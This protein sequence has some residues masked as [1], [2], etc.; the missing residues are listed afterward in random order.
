MRSRF[1]R[2]FAALL[3]G[4][5]IAQAIPILI[6]PILTRLYSPS[7]FGMLALYLG[8]VNILAVVATGRYEAAIV[9]PKSSK[10]AAGILALCFILTLATVLLVALVL[11]GFGDTLLEL[12]DAT[13][14]GALVYLLPISILL[15]ASMQILNYW[16]TR[17]GSFANIATAQVGQSLGSAFLQPSLKLLGYNGGLI[18][19]NL[20]ARAVG[21]AILARSVLK[22][23][24]ELFFK[25]EWR[26]LLL[27]A[28]THS[29]FPRANLPHAL[30]D[31]A[32]NSGSVMLLASLFGQSVLGLYSL[33]LRVLQVPVGIIGSALSQLL[34]KE[35]SRRKNE[36]RPLYP[37]VKRVF[38]YLLTIALPSF[39]LLYLF[40]P[41]LFGLVFGKEWREAGEYGRLLIPYLLLNFLLSPLSQLPILLEWQKEI[42]HISLIGNVG[43]LAIIWIAHPYGIETTL[44]LLSLF[45]VLYYLNTLYLLRKELLCYEQRVINS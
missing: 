8:L 26:H 10:D 4:T 16:M 45:M 18:L 39:L 28:K 12:L 29:T 33:A 20:G 24:K 31:I 38:L 32:K 23:D 2:D 36:Q 5:T 34:Y 17:K 42:F 13:E 9:L 15:A 7:E 1:F 14:L 3:S 6:S 41:D 27:L 30:S 22:D 21:T 35:L 43:Y 37:Y 25:L 44:T 19:G 11:L 40:L